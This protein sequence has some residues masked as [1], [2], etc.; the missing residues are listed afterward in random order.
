[1]LVFLYKH[2]KINSYLKVFDDHDGNETYVNH[3]NYLKF[4]IW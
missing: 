2:F 1:M 4:P 3:H